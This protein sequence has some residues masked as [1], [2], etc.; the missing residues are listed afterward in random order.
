MTQWGR[1]EFSPDLPEK[2]R[3]FQDLTSSV[4]ILYRPLG[5]SSAW[6]HGVEFVQGTAARE[7]DWKSIWERCFCHLLVDLLPDK[8]LAELKQQLSDS[9]IFYS[10][11]IPPTL[12]PPSQRRTSPVLNHYDREVP[13][14]DEE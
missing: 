14:L 13:T 2:A 12:P 10:H 6:Y 9:I 5:G 7:A 4:R 11:E 8:G 3:E 1:D